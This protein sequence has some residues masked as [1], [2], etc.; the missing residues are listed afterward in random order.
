M[1]V[2]HKTL[3][4]EKWQALNLREQMGNIGSEISRAQNPLN[5]PQAVERALELIDLT[6]AD[7]KLK[8]KKEVARV[9]E[10]LCD[11]VY[12]KNQY[13][14]SL[15]DL[16]DYFFWFAVAARSGK[17]KVLNLIFWLFRFKL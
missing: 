17:W 12:G 11:T 10:F 1:S 5:Q 14:T 4:Q 15:K 13:N 16:N 3:T 2:I 7:P 6:L 9:R 8:H